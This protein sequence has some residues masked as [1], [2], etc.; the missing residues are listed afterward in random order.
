[1]IVA[2]PGSAQQTAHWVGS[3]RCDIQV[4]GRDSYQNPDG[5]HTHP[6]QLSGGTSASS[7]FCIVSI[8]SSQAGIRITGDRMDLSV[9]AH[10]V[11]VAG[12]ALDVVAAFIVQAD[13]GCAGSGLGVAIL[14]ASAL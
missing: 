10:W 5:W 4:I 2:I 6:V 11:P 7:D 1:M 13:T 9:P 8:G 14:G 12:A 3:I